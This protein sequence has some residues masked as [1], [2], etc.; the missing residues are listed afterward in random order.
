MAAVKFTPPN[1]FPLGLIRSHMVVIH[2]FLMLCDLQRV[3]KDLCPT[4][5]ITAIYFF[6]EVNCKQK[7]PVRMCCTQ[8]NRQLFDLPRFIPCHITARN[9]LSIRN[10]NN[11]TS[12]ACSFVHQF[13]WYQY[14]RKTARLPFYS[15]VCFICR[16]LCL[17]MWLCESGY[18]CILCICWAAAGKMWLWLCFIYSESYLVSLW[19]HRHRDRCGS[20]VQGYWKALEGYQS[21]NVTHARILHVCYGFY[22]VQICPHAQET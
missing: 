14:I 3:V 15:S 19:I 16:I 22:P 2:L 17:I 4:L 11:Q 7:L 5:Y 6:T 20:K 18:T 13:R 8:R 10:V 12:R 1:D 9:S 21:C